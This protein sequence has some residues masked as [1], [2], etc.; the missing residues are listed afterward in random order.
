[1]SRWTIVLGGQLS[2]G[3]SCPGGQLSR[4]TTV[5]GDKCW[6]DKCRG[7]ACQGD[8]CHTTFTQALHQMNDRLTVF[9]IKN[10][11]E[12]RLATIQCLGTQ[13]KKCHKFWKK[14][15]IF[16]SPPRIICTI[17]NLGKK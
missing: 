14:S 11:K 13:S 6:G 15:I 4:G 2:W 5:Q 8:E 16:L 1:M 9:F 10:Q 7:D 3:D 12:K 17:L